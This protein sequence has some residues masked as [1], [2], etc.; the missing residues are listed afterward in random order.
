MARR[1]HGEGSFYQ[2]TRPNG[3]KIWRGA[4]TIPGG[5]GGRQVR[6][7]VSSTTRREAR[8]K[9]DALRREID[10]GALPDQQITV[11]KWVR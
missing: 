5:G 2:V 4:I 3:S 1:G 7:T 11:E 10:D 8:D 6:R 9:L